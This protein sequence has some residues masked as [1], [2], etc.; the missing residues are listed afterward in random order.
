MKH[1]Y[2]KPVVGDKSPC[3]SKGGRGVRDVGGLK[4]FRQRYHESRQQHG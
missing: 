1:E 3:K 2:D 4:R